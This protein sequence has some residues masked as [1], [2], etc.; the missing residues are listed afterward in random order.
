MRYIYKNNQ[1]KPGIK[2]ILVLNN[3]E[4]IMKNND[5]QRYK[6]SWS[7]YKNAIREWLM[8]P[9]L[10]HRVFDLRLECLAETLLQK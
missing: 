1:K 7:Q 5:Q 3:S 4:G 9:R 10:T 8:Y 6:K 2:R